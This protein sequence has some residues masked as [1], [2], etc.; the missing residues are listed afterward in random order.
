[1]I[2]HLLIKSFLMLAIFM[3]GG[4]Y[5]AY[6]KGVDVGS[7]LS[8]FADLP[9]LSGLGELDVETLSID[10]ETREGD[11]RVLK[12]GRQR[13]Y[14]WQDRDGQ[15]H[16]TQTRPPP[17]AV[18]ETSMD[19]DPN[20]NV[21]AGMRPKPPVEEEAPDEAPGKGKDLS[22]AL[23]DSPYSPETIKKMFEDAQALQEKL[24]E[25]YESQVQQIQGQ[26]R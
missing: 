13:V 19:L 10:S 23:P 11:T 6:L 1:M 14:K 2:K 25:R 18:A 3:G 9:S 24:N 20:L 22:E 7:L 16:Y 21:I 17:D 15:W 8:R 5:L 12:A 4:A 26:T